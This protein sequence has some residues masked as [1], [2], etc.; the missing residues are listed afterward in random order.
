M[1]LVGGGFSYG[2]C[3]QGVAVAMIVGGA[4]VTISIGD[5]SSDTNRQGVLVQP[6]VLVS[7]AL[8]WG[9]SVS[10]GACGT[11]SIADCLSGTNR[12]GVLVLPVVLV[13]GTLVWETSVSGVARGTIRLV[14]LLWHLVLSH[15][16]G[17]L[18]VHPVLGDTFVALSVSIGGA[19]LALNVGGR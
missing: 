17:R 8:G 12:R 11:I 13:S 3:G 19:H 10:G 6:V 9:P 1:A 14:M 16:Q 4:R 18:G 2:A 7:S 15:P 5:C